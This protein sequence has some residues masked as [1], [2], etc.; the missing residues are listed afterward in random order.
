MSVKRYVVDNPTIHLDRG[1][2]ARYS[3]GKH[4]MVMLSDHLADRAALLALLGGKP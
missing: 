2:T 4:I 3:P 1:E